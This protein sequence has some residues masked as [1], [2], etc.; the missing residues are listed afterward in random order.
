MKDASA[1]KWVE[2]VSPGDC[3][4]AV[5]ARTLQSRLGVV[6][7]FLPLAAERA[8]EDTNYIHELRVWTRRA[9]AALD[10]YQ[11]LMPRRRFLWMKKQ[12]KRVRRAANDARDCDV[13]IE[14]LRKKQSSRGAKRWLEAV[15]AER[16]EAQQAVVGAYE[17][18]GRGHRF[19]RRIDK[20]LERVRSRTKE[21]AGAASARF[22]DWAQER[23]RPLVEQF[24]AAV[25][26]D[27]TDEA[28]L[29][30]LRVRGKELR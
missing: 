10:L 5:A 15:R 4:G 16:E 22:K 20:L 14:R 29:H 12:L 23:L 9:A 24:F 1:E 21:K 19:A 17:R 18:L 7:R 27:R 30:R 2:R 8:E 25:P 28:A 3:T 13:L 6:L 11:D 26:S